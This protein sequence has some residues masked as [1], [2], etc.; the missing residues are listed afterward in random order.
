MDRP[1][2]WIAWGRRLRTEHRELRGKKS[3]KMKYR[4][5]V[6]LL[7]MRLPLTLA[8]R[9]RALALSSDLRT[10]GLSHGPVLHSIGYKSILEVRDCYGAN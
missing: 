7:G 4:F 2:C 1:K 3:G 6:D 5:D 8:F 10:D 9:M